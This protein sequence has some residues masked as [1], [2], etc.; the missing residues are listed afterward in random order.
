LA[1]LK[2]DFTLKDL[3]NLSYFLGI[4]V[5]Q[6]SDGILLSQEKYASDIPRRAGMLTCKSA[7]TPMAA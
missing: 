1:D 4:Q 2:S 6:L 7:P 3:G 5:K